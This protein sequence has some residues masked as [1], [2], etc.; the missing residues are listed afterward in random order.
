[1]TSQRIAELKA[2]AKWGGH[3]S[4]ILGVPELIAE[5]ESL[6]AE[7]SALQAQGPAAQG[8]GGAREL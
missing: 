3:Y 4:D 1:M 7:L 5:V 8:A 2:K 6:V